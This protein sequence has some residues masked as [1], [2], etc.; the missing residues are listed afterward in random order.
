MNCAHGAAKA[1]V[2]GGPPFGRELVHAKVPHGWRA[3]DTRKGVKRAADGGQPLDR[4]GLSHGHG[5]GDAAPAENDRGVIAPKAAADLQ[6]RS[7]AR[8]RSHLHRRLPPTDD[9]LDS[10]R[11]D[12]R[13]DFHTAG[14]GGGAQDIADRDAP[15]GHRR[16]LWRRRGWRHHGHAAAPCTRARRAASAEACMADFRSPRWPQGRPSQ[17]TS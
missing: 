17:D 8:L 5:V 1:G 13:G 14:D 4:S 9:A 11:S 15:C 16:Q 6:H 3:A 10:R 7:A 12:Q 2:V